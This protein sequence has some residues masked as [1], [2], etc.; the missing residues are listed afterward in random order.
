MAPKLDWSTD[1][2]QPKINRLVASLATE[3]AKRPTTDN[4]PVVPLGSSADDVIA[5]L[6]AIGLFVQE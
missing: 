2:A 3:L 5:A 6:Q 1:L 4:P